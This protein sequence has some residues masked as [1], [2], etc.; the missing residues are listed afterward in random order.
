MGRRHRA[1]AVRWER[2]TVGLR[3]IPLTPLPSQPDRK[4]RPDAAT[5]PD[6]RSPVG[7]AD[8]EI[9]YYAE[10][11]AVELAHV[12]ADVLT[13][14]VCRTVEDLFDDGKSGPSVARVFAR[15][16]L[17]YGIVDTDETRSKSET[18]TVATLQDG[19]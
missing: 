16:L 5:G 2:R 10:V 7:T 17:Q 6:P 11:N 18:T 8:S 9:R 15:D 13:D 1:G 19:R 12:D 4:R 14:A 3:T